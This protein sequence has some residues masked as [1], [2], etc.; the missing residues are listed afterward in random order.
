MERLAEAVYK[1]G[2]A[3]R[4]PPEQSGAPPEKE[5][6]QSSGVEARPAAE[7]R[8]AVPARRSRLVLATAAVLVGAAVGA[9]ATALGLDAS[10]G[11]GS[12]L[13][14]SPRGRLVTI[15]NEVTNGPT[16]MRQDGVGVYLS[17]RPVDYCLAQGC[18]DQSLYLASG[19]QIRVTCETSGQL[20]TNGDDTNRL[21]ANNPGRASASLWFGVRTPVG[22]LD[23]FS[24]VWSAVA[25]RG[26][27][28]PPRCPNR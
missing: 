22:R 11:R 17:T 21:D 3:E 16:G 18:A 26:G 19:S 10:T 28:G 23:Y 27:L 6:F 20:T 1:N 15:D 12:G 25:D 2:F 7:P 14:L 4:G 8:S 24:A 13:D 5:H 9:S